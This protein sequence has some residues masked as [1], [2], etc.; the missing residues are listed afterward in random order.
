M[1][2]KL[3]PLVFDLDSQARSK[4]FGTPSTYSKNISKI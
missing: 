1:G 3:I 2:H 4:H